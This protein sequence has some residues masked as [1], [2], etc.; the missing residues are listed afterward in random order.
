MSVLFSI[1]SSE[2]NFGIN[3]FYRM[4]FHQITIFFLNFEVWPGDTIP[5]VYTYIFNDILDLCN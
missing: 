1:P 2:I 3:L 4:S 5:A